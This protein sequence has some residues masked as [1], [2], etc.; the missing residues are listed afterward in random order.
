M[1]AKKK[2]FDESVGSDDFNYT[3]VTEHFDSE[4]EKVFCIVEN[5]FKSD[6]T[7]KIGR[8]EVS[9]SI[10]DYEEIIMEN[11]TAAEISFLNYEILKAEI[12]S[13]LKLS[14]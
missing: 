13:E 14:M 5:L 12:I 4:T 2:Y 6:S 1:E 3:K 9:I 11:S 10:Q 7:I 8:R